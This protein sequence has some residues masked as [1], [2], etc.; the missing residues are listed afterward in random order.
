MLCR[1]GVVR[2]LQTRLGITSGN[3]LATIRLQL[4]KTTIK[5]DPTITNSQFK[6]SL[7]LSC[8]I[9]LDS[10]THFRCLIPVDCQ[11]AKVVA[12]DKEKCCAVHQRM[13]K[14]G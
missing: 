9:Q 2:V 4:F 3:D 7:N 6:E 1:T 14:M 10:Q 12:S 8:T 5:L 11:C 13:I